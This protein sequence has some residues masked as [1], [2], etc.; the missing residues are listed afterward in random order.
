MWF[1]FETNNAYERRNTSSSDLQ[2]WITYTYVGDPRFV[3]FFL[4]L[5]ANIMT[6][7]RSTQ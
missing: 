6:D 1:P 7:N 3:H 5:L 4:P 2:P